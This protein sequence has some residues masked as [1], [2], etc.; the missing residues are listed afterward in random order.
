MANMN[1]CRH[2]N[3]LEDLKDCYDNM[4]EAVD[5]V[6]GVARLRLIKLCVQVA[7]NYADEIGA[8]G[9]IEQDEVAFRLTLK[10]AREC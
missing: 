1:H 10:S 4:D 5:T 6:E 3:T 8:K 7:N 2:S 9:D